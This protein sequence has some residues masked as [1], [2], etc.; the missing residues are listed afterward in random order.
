MNDGSVFCA[1]IQTVRLAEGWITLMSSEDKISLNDV[2]SA[3]TKGER[4][5]VGEVRDVDQLESWRDSMRDA[6]KHGWWGVNED[7]PLAQWEIVGS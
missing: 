3:V 6:R 2:K 5:R 4:Y 1:P 7:T